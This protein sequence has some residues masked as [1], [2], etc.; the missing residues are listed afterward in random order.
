MCLSP[1]VTDTSIDNNVKATS[2]I[3]DIET[4]PNGEFESETWG[5]YSIFI[6]PQQHCEKSH[7]SDKIIICAQT[8]LCGTEAVL[9]LWLSWSQLSSS[10]NYKQAEVKLSQAQEI[11]AYK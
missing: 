4:E 3:A 5:K 6:C 2:T 7:F 10:L 11:D 1:R 9:G 8:Q